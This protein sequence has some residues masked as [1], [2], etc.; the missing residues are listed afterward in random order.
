MQVTNLSKKIKGKYVLKGVD[1]ALDKKCTALLGPNGAGKTTL[2]KCMAGILAATEGVITASDDERTLKC[3]YLPQGFTFLPNLTVWESLNYLS[4]LN[5]IP[6]NDIGSEVS[7]VVELANLRDFIDVKVK[8]LSGG[9]LRRL[10][11][12]QALL[13][14][15]RLL[16]LDEPT[17]GLDIEERAKLKVVLAKIKES[18]TVFISTHLLEDIVGLCDRVLVLREG[19]L[20]FN[21]ELEEI[22]SFAQGR[23]SL[24]ENEDQR[25]FGGINSGSSFISGKMQYRFVMPKKTLNNMIVPTIEDGYLA[26]LHGFVD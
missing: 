20:I 16:L 25:Q 6:Q 13:G 21:G 4:H 11:I 19:S 3:G 17:A 2:I 1:F 15:P 23:I 24:S 7:R 9:T 14:H 22:S 26:L 10:G 8:A 12:A 5:K 18:N